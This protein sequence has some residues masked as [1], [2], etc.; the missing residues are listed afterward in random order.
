MP[1]R[2]DGRLLCRAATQR[3]NSE[4]ARPTSLGRINC[5]SIAVEVSRHHADWQIWGLIDAAH[6]QAGRLA[7][8]SRDLAAGLL[9]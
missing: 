4:S 5:T 8:A 2:A 3:A 1:G 7:T 6:S 9:D